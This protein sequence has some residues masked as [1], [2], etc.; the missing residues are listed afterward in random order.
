M[1]DFSSKSKQQR[2][3]KDVQKANSDKA[4]FNL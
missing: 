1:K 4:P 3:Y 2:K